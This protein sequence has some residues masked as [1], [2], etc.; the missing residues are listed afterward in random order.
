MD[1]PAGFKALQETIQGALIATTRTATAI[2]AGDIP[3]QRSLDPDLAESLDS[4]IARLLRLAERALEASA[5]A[6]T[7]TSLK[8]PDADAI[9]GNWRDV[10][11]VIDSLLEKA[12]TSLDEYT[13]AVKRLSPAEDA[14][15]SLPID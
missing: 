6:S 13:G 5:V 9:D 10:V 14:V 3:F 15:C 12:D 1:S 2:S 7:A 8:L 11:D 4:E